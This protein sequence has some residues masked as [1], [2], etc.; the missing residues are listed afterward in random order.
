MIDVDQTIFSHV[1]NRELG[2]HA[3][4]ARRAIASKG[5]A[6]TNAR[7]GEDSR[8]VGPRRKISLA[9]HGGD[10]LDEGG[11]IFFA[12]AIFETDANPPLLTKL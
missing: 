11:F 2:E 8:P 5:T 9:S 6:E 3:S 1:H 10:V 7:S 4:T 12:G